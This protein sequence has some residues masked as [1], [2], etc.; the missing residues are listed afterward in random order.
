[1]HWD[2]IIHAEE[3]VC[4][5]EI[6][7][8]MLRSIIRFNEILISGLIFMLFESPLLAN[9]PLKVR[10]ACVGDSITVGVGTA[11]PNVES[12]PAQLGKLLGDKY[13]VRNFG[14]SGATA[15][16]ASSPKSYFEQP[17]FHAAT[18]FQP[19]VVI[20]MLGTND[21]DPPLWADQKQHFKGDYGA[22][23]AH[24]AGLG[25]KPMVYLCLPVPIRPGDFNDRVR[26]LRDEV[27][28]IIREIA[29]ERNLPLIDLYKPLENKLELLPDEVHPNAAGA[30][31]IAETVYKTLNQKLNQ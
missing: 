20:F 2:V 27:S 16:K 6:N 17:E 29:I 28:P 8:S 23:V 11:N 14:H 3:S 5:K 18:D 25:S 10:V 1:M 13:E 7:P 19:K 30:A 15:L 21:A 12:Y 22:L 24:F 4:Q 26:Y 9:P 31:I